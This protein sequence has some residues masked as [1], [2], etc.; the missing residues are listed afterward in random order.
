MTSSDAL[1]K[2]SDLT[3]YYGQVRAL[4]GISLE[5]RPGEVVSLL[6]ANGAGKSTTLMTI[7][8]LVRARQGTVS[9][10]G[11]RTDALEPHHIARL[12][13]VQVPEGRRVFPRLSVQVNL[14]L[15]AFNRPPADLSDSYDRVFALFPVLKERRGQMAGTL[16]GGEQQMLSI[17]RALMA[18]PKLLLMDEPSMGLAPLLVEQVFGK[19]AE[20]N[21]QGVCI[22]L[23]EQNASMALEV[24]SRGYVLQAGRIVHEG[25]AE[26]LKEDARVQAAYLGG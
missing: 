15:G 24:A 10:G 4:E 7:S 17:G 12:G 11:R 9:F 21:R 23:V 14:R 20:I 19:I 13:L 2:V 22:L 6:G 3:V 1:L 25:P 16:S 8:G 5:I 18:D 26:V